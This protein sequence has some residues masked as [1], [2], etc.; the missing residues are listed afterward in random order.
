M[1]IEWTPP[2]RPA[3]ARR[4]ERGA[5]AAGRSFAGQISEEAAPA[6]TPAAS[7]VVSID[8]LFALQEVSDAITG[9]RRAVAR[10]K[11][12]LDRL[13]RLRLALLDG[14][15]PREDLRA[16]GRLAREQGPIVQD[17]GLAEVLAEIE[18]R[19]AVELAKLGEEL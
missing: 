18:L 19:V 10:G 13:D 9:R 5:A 16:L 8:G 14:T 11:A 15:L 1:R 3:T 4:D 6:S 7:P 2:V 17:G 12:L